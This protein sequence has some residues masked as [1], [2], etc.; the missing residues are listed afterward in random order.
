[1]LLKLQNF[2]KD[3]GFGRSPLFPKAYALGNVYIIFMYKGSYNGIICVPLNSTIHH[4]FSLFLT[5]SHH[6]LQIVMFCHHSSLF[7]ILFRIAVTI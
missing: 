6:T 4:Y 1:M 5:I 2:M 3:G 7:L